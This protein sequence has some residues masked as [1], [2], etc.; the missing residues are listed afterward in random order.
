MNRKKCYFVCFKNFH[1]KRKIASEMGHYV[2]VTSHTLVW[3]QHRAV[4]RSMYIKTKIISVLIMY[5]FILVEIARLL[6]NCW[7]AGVIYVRSMT[8]GGR[9]RG[10]LLKTFQRLQ[11]YCNYFF[12]FRHSTCE[13]HWKVI[14]HSSVRS[15]NNLATI[16]HQPCN[17][18]DKIVLQTILERIIWYLYS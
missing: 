15:C 7:Q 9:V 11:Q 13:K 14:L 18:T 8:S 1:F 5:L 3:A 2:A 16:M 6:Q 17:A 4:T 10:M 12:P